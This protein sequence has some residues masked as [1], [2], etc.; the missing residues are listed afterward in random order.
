MLDIFG[1]ERHAEHRDDMDGAGSF[2]DDCRTLYVG[3]LKTAVYETAAGAGQE[4]DKEGRRNLRKVVRK[5]FKEFGEIEKVNVIWRLSI[6]FVRYRLRVAA[7]FAKEAMANQSLGHDEVLN[8]KW[9]YEDPNPHV[10]REVQRSNEDAMAAAI[11]AKGIQVGPII[12][13]AERPPSLPPAKRIK[14]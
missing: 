2:Q 7:E 3:G 14:R 13:S 9:A 11:R 4:L 1:R 5:H 6:A 12:P 8:V 10:K